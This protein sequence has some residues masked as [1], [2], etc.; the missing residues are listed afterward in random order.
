M[1]KAKIVNKGDLKYHATTQTSSFDMASDGTAPNPV[2]TL[3]ASLCACLGHYVGDFLRQEKIA[4]SEYSV[5]AES[6]LTE[7]HVRLADIR[8][9]IE[10]QNAV[11]NEAMRSSMLDFITKCYIY[12]TLKANS[13][14]TMNVAAG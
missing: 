7:D 12:N 9:A 13:R 1:F 10:V 5:S 3:L 8:V 14:I 6:E 4:F 11:W 2:D